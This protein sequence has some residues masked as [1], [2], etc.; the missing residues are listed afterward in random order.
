[1]RCGFT[2]NRANPMLQTVPPFGN[3]KSKAGK[4][5]NPPCSYFIM[6]SKKK[7]TAALTSSITPR[8]VIRSVRRTSVRRFPILPHL[9]SLPPVATTPGGCHYSRRFS[10]GLYGRNRFTFHTS[11]TTSAISESPPTAISPF[12]M[13]DRGFSTSFSTG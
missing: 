8:G 11:I 5:R 7:K 4:L 12:S 3:K 2:D 10:S 6:F 13:F 1:M 9:P